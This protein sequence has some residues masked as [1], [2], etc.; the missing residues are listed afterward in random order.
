[1]P[2]AKSSPAFPVYRGGIDVAAKI[3]A[4][5]FILAGIGLLYYGIDHVRHPSVSCGGQRM[6]SGAVCEHYTNGRDTG[7]SSA[8]QQAHGDQFAGYAA[9]VIGGIVLL[10]GAGGGYAVITSK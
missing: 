6:E 5:V 10:L 1:M 4:V 8:S 2:G 9:I 7:G 3:W